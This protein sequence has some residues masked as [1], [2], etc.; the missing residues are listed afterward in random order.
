MKKKIYILSA[1]FIHCCATLIAQ[2]PMSSDLQNRLADKRKYSE[3][4]AEVDQYYRSNNFVSNPELY[5]EYKKWKRWAWFAVRHLNE[6]GEVDYKTEFIHD[7]SNQISQRLNLTNSNSGFWSFVGPSST[8]WAINRGSRGIG[9]VDRLAFHPTDPLVII[10]GT[11]AGGLWRTNDAASNWFPIS[12]NIP[13]CGIS[14]IVVGR[15]NPT[16]NT[17]Y[18]LTG[19][20]DSGVGGFVWSYLYARTSIGVLVTTDAGNTWTKLGNSQTVLNGRTCYQ[21]LQH[22]SQHN[23]LMAA[24]DNGVYRTTDW[25]QTWTLAALAG[26]AVFDL[27]QHPT[28]DN[29]VYAALNN[30][31]WKS[32]DGGAT[33]T[34]NPVFT[35][36]ANTATRSALA[37]TNASPNEV[38]FLQASAGYNRI[39]L[40]TNSGDNYSSINTTDLVTGQYGY[41]CSFAVSHAD[42]NRIVAG[43]IGISRSSDNGITFPDQTVGIV[44]NTPPTSRYVHPDIHDLA[45]NPLNAANGVVYAATDGGV[46]ISLDNG[47]NWIDRSDGLNCTQYYH[48]DGFNNSAN[49]LIGGAQDNGTAFTTNGSAMNYCGSGDG[50]AVDFVCNDNNV[51]Y[52]I[53]NTSVSRYTRS[54]AT[55]TTISPGVANDQSFY[56]NV[57]SHPTNG[58]IVYAGYDS[59]MWRSNNQGSSWTNISNNNSG[60]SNGGAGH[61]GGFAV[62]AATPDRIYVTDA[63]TVR[64]SDNQGTNWTTIS[65]NTGW[66]T[67]FGVITD[68]AARNNNANEVWITVAGSNGANKVF[69]S[70]DAGANWFNFT[71]SLPNIPIYC[72]AYTDAG[73]VY[74]GTELGVFFMDFAMNDWVPYYNGLPRV[75]VSDLFVNETLSTIQASTFGRGIWQSDLYSDCPEWWLFSG[76]VSGYRTYQSS[77]FIETSHQIAGS[78]GNDIRYRATQKITLKPGFRASQNSYM[79]AVIGNCGQVIFRNGDSSIQ[80]K[81]EYLRLNGQ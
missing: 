18:I 9:R 12:G 43:G 30:S 36:A 58:T 74:I 24:T 6:Q 49:L 14:G 19:D 39:Y 53:E 81:K 33:F 11:P 78:F 52:L 16:G 40:S 17:I 66:Q 2:L 48:M 38:Y 56:P 42:K 67:N 27:E 15:E 26:N 10:A 72:I 46:Y 64:R 55:R 20:G 77:N 60:S 37:V 21:L 59:T 13:N 51:F 75:P 8:T 80:T 65:G 32:T 76:N 4:M 1:I 71:G 35:P 69:Y 29:I 50:F 61:T 79:R 68:I 34:V 22:R 5:R 44:N 3:I 62:S 63:T 57:I 7:L 45:F 47:L 23:I 25:G 73:D 54:T 70:D 31:A 41:N 28:N